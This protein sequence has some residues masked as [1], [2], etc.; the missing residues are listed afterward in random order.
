MCL[1]LS[2]FLQYIAKVL[3]R[4]TQQQ[5]QQQKSITTTALAMTGTTAAA[6]GVGAVLPL[7]QESSP[8]I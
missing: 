2:F 8:L 3:V 6:V 1:L 4:P 7:I 5:H